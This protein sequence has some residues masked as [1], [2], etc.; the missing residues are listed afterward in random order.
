MWQ[1]FV[2]I[3]ALRRKRPE[4]GKISGEI[5]YPKSVVPIASEDV[6]PEHEARIVALMNELA[7]DVPPEPT[8]S[9]DD[10]SR[11]DI[12]KCPLRAS[13][14]GEFDGDDAIAAGF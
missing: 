8:P 7:S 2:Y 14:V 10:C 6:T 3:F 5:V 13:A 1:L 9:H 12:A 4:L 11:C